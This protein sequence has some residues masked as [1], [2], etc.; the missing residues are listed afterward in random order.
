MTKRELSWKRYFLF[1]KDRCLKMSL[2]GETMST[3]RLEMRAG[4]E[5]TPDWQRS[6]CE[7]P[8]RFASNAEKWHFFCE[9]WQY[10]RSSQPSFEGVRK[11][12]W[13]RSSCVLPFCHQLLW[14]KGS[15]GEG[16]YDQT[17]KPQL[18]LF[19]RWKKKFKPKCRE[20]TI[21]LERCKI[22]G[23]F[24]HSCINFALSWCGYNKM[25]IGQN[26]E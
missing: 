20:C 13:W 6:L 25:G 10:S 19:W 16:D 18:S 17:K 11:W 2:P 8:T 21:E 3:W 22:C 1:H 9:L 7:V 12:Q 14:K 5:P 4:V 26:W 24:G 15:R 23:E